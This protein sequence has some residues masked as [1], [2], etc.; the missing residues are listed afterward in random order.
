MTEKIP[1]DS[2]GFRPALSILFIFIAQ[3]LCNYSAY[4]QDNAYTISRDKLVETLKKKH[5]DKAWTQSINRFYFNTCDSLI[6]KN[7]VVDS[8]SI[9]VI[10]TRLFDASQLKISNKSVSVLRIPSVNTFFMQTLATYKKRPLAGLYRQIGITQIAILESTF[11]GLVL[12]DSI[13]LVVG[14]REMLSNPFLISTRLADPKYLPFR[15]TL[16]YFL[17]NGAPEILSEK[18]AGNDPLFTSLANKSTNPTVR[19]VTQIAKDNYYDRVLPFGLAIQENRVTE[20]SIRKLSLNPSEYYRAFADETIRLYTNPDRGVKLYLEQP[21]AA[22]NKSLA[23]KFYINEINTLHDSPDKV[24]FQILNN[25]SARE[26]YFLLIGGSGQLYTSSFLYLYKK[27]IAES[28][29]EGLDK[30]LKDVDYYQFGQFVSNISVYRLVDEFIEHLHEEKFAEL[31]RNY[32]SKNLSPRLSDNEIMLNAMTISEI[33]SEINHHP[34][35]QRNLLGYINTYENAKVKQDIMLQRIF[36]GLKNILMNKTD[37]T[38]DPTYD[39]LPIKRLQKNNAIVQAAFFYDDEDGAGSFASSVASYDKKIWDKT[40]KGNYVVFNSLSGNNMRVYMNKPNTKPGSDS[41]QDEMLRH[42]RQEDY[43]VTSF[44]HRGHSYHLQQSLRKITPAAAFVFLGSC[45]GYSEVLN[46][47]NLNPDVNIIVS[48]NIGS[49]LI[50]DPLLQRINLDL[51]NNKDI[52]WNNT[53]AHFNSVFTSKQ[54]KDLFSSYIPPNKYVGVKFI[55]KVL[56]Y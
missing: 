41:A 21:I 26:L 5:I 12:G 4:S 15:D 19:A 51:V 28:Q 22:L 11:D 9:K 1:K 48:R 14:I 39:V 47:F 46:V 43:E 56:S 44:I 35:V 36:A 17:A 50:N 3:F 55:R 49:M 31:M 34:V 2:N 38:S 13:G 45:G 16:L 7:V 18:L 37:Y 33:L 6:A 53:W 8:R 52:N 30:F 42:I 29:K 20:D 27:F 54:T 10:L 24:R 25:L 32:F 23:N 40:D